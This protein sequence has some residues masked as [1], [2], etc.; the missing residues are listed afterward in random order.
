M[1][2]LLGGVAVSFSSCGEA[3]EGGEET[4]EEAADESHD[5]GGH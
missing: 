1:M 4:T 2:F 5:E 3:E